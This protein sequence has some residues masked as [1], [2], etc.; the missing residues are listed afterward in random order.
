[1][2]SVLIYTVHKAASTFLHKISTDVANEFGICYYSINNDR[3]YDE[4]KQLSWKTFIED[5]SKQGCFG[6]IR[7]GITE[8][9][10][11]EALSEYSIV[12]HLRDS[13][14]CFNLPVLLPCLQP[15]KTK[16]KI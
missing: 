8:A 2:K 16:R 10:F 7:A 13:E 4:I 11:P 5:K 3:Y 12:L 6:P 15:S 14:R 1:M 9:I